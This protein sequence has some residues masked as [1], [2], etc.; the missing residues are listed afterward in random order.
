MTSQCCLDGVVVVVVVFLV[1]VVDVVVDMLKLLLFRSCHREGWR[2]WLGK[3][4]G[5]SRS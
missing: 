3:W 2:W 5:A 4:G 1:V